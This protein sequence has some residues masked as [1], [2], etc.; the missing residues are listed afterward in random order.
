MATINLGAIK[1]NW[2]GPYN[3]GTTYAVD[4]VVSSGG[5]SYVCIQAHTNQPVGNATAYWNIMSSAGTNGTNGTDLT[6]TLTTQGD[7]V[8]RDG[9]GLQR[10]PKGTASQVLAINSGATA[11]EWVDPAGGM[12]KKLST[13]TLGSDVSTVEFTN[14]YLTNAY[15]D[16]CVVV[17]NFVSGGEVTFRTRLRKV[18]DSSFTTNHYEY[19]VRC[20]KSDGTHDSASSP[21]D[22][23]WKITPNNNRAQ[24]AK[25]G[26]FRITY[27]NL[28]D[29]NSYA[30]YECEG[31]FYNNSDQTCVLYGA[32]FLNDGA[33]DTFDRILLFMDSGVIKAGTIFDLYGRA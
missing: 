31:S 3:N 10:L 20:F 19:A 1:F 30:G 8:Y 29:T 13:Q 21:S 2:K 22:S 28:F 17:A 9:S 23:M 18:G 12:W 33:S 4:D 11:P 32:G 5:S 25:P 16:Y 15:K 7:L 14:T 26:S 24:T 27:N 6:S